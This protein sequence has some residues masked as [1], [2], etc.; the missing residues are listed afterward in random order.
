MLGGITQDALLSGLPYS[1]AFLG[2]W[3]TFRL[4]G[5]FDI[6]VDNMFALG[7]AVYGAWVLH[8]G[9]ALVGTVFAAGAGALAGGLI[10]AVM[11]LLKLSLLLASIIVGTGLFSANLLIMG[12]PNLN[13]FGSSNLFQSWADTLSGGDLNTAVIE[14]AGLIAVAA[15]VLLLIFLRTEFGLLMRANGLNRKMVLGNAGSPSRLLLL[16]VVAGDCLVATSGAL[17]AQ[18]QGFS[19]IE[20]GLGTLVAAITAIL[21]GEMITGRTGATTRGVLAVLIGALIYRAALS[22]AFRAGLDPSY[23]QGITALIVFVLL[24]LRRAGGRLSFQPA[25]VRQRLLARRSPVGAV[26]ESAAP[27]APSEE[28]APEP[29]TDIR[30]R[31]ASEGRL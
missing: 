3:M 4:Q 29:G 23:F 11:R 21:I 27:A 22:A 7:G 13:L 25:T 28:P 15:F 12:V 1:L 14:L 16:S 20:M 2:V 9:N 8:G 24:G 5:E 30:P 6:S 17:V 10:Y 18:Q 26:A 19:D 31:E